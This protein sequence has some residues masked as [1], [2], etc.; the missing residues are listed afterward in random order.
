MQALLRDLALM[1]L[2]ARLSV[3]AAPESSVTPLY[4]IH[5][6][7]S[8]SAYVSISRPRRLRHTCIRHTSAYVSVSIRQYR[9]PQTPA[10]HLYTAYISIR[11]RQHTSV[12]AA[13][14]SCVTPVYSIR[15]HTSASAYVSIG[16]PRRLRHTC[17]QHT[18]SYV[19]VSIRQYRPPQT[20]ASNL[21]ILRLC[22]SCL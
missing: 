15:H 4:S 7:T 6:H 11:Q 10:S 13:P 12:S 19:S 14:E 2:A 8:A 22:Q 18:S 9:P 1:R 3:S 17:I 21:Y 16:R 20:P 5:Q